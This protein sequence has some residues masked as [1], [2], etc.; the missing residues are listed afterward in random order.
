MLILFIW[1]VFIG[2]PY[3]KVQENPKMT[4]MLL[5]TTVNY[6]VHLPDGFDTSNETYPAIC[7]L[8]KFIKD[9]TNWTKLG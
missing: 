8:N 1:T 3:S 9:K 2:N 7:L 6:S 5:D 4:R